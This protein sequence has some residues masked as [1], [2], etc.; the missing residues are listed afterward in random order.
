MTGFYNTL[1][2]FDLSDET[3][4]ALKGK[5]LQ[6]Q[7]KPGSK[8]SINEVAAGLGVSRTP[9]V[10]A[11]Q[12]LAGEGLVEIHPRRGTFVKGIT[13]DEVEGVFEVRRMVELYAAQ[14]ILEKELVQQFLDCIRPAQDQMDRATSGEDYLDY[15][16]FMQ[17]D[18]DFHAIL[19]DQTGNRR[20]IDIY[21]DLNAHM[22]VL[23]AHYVD[24]VENARQTQREHLAFVEALESG[25]LGKIQAA[26]DNHIN[27][28]KSRIIQLIQE[29]GGR[30]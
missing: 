8:I 28:V 10:V 23:R 27:N 4:N 18:H 26:V 13:A 6:R 14:Y 21:R 16:A 24:D 29:E 2:H 5:I 22:H 30:I 1:E 19:V 15:Q 7:L 12:R 20:L 3:Y 25:D 17:G 11:L 9:V